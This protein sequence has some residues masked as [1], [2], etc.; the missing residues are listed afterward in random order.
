MVDHGATDWRNLF[1]AAAD[2]ALKCFPPNLV[3]GKALIAPPREIFEEGEHYWKNAIV[4]QFVGKIPNF[5]AFQKMVNI[6]WGE[7]GTM[8]IRPAGINLFIVQF[9]NPEMRDKV[10]E[11]GPWH[12]QNKPIIIGKWEPGLRTLEFNMAKLPIW[13][14]LSNIPLELFT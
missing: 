4:A 12:L 7:S 3:N 1:S 11:L 9:P 13:L 8:D 14:Q 10:L 2:Q 6:L 5:G